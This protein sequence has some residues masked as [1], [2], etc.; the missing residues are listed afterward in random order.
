MATG[1]TTLEEFQTNA[2]DDLAE[3]YTF[4]CEGMGVTTL[5]G[6]KLKAKKPGITLNFLR[7]GLFKKDTEQP[8]R[9]IQGNP[10]NEQEGKV[11]N[12]KKSKT[13]ETE[14]SD[15]DMVITL[16]E[17]VVYP[18]NNEPTIENYSYAHTGLREGYIY[19][20]DDSD[21]DN[22]GLEYWVDEFGYLLPVIWKKGCEKAGNDGYFDI[23][24]PEGEGKDVI[25]EQDAV[26]WIAFSPVQWSIVFHKEMR[27]NAEK[28]EKRMTKVICSGFKKG[29]AS[30][31]EDVLPYNEV[32]ACFNPDQKSE[33]RKFKQKLRQ[34]KADD[35][36][37]EELKEDMFVVLHDPISCADDLAINL[38]LE[39]LRLRA[40]IESM[41]TG[42]D[43][44][45]IFDRMLK[46]KLS[47]E[48]LSK[49]Q[50]QISY[51]FTLAQTTYHLVYNDPKMIKDYDGGNTGFLNW[52][53]AGNGISKEKI[54]KILGVEER[55]EQRKIIAKHR[56]AFGSFL[57]STYYRTHWK[58][59]QEN[60]HCRILDGKERVLQH[61]SLLARH[62]HS[63]DKYLDLK[64]DDETSN[65][66]YVSFLEKI[67]KGEEGS[68]ICELLKED[69]DLE[70]ASIEAE[71]FLDRNKQIDLASKAGGVI[72]GI[73]ESFGAL[74]FKTYTTFAAQ[75]NYA[76]KITRINAVVEAIFSNIKCIKV[77]GDVIFEVSLGEFETFL[78][79]SG[80]DAV[81]YKDSI[82]LTEADKK[83]RNPKK[84]KRYQ[85]PEINTKKG[86]VRMRQSMSIALKDKYKGLIAIPLKKLEVTQEPN[87]FTLV[88]EDVTETNPKAL[89]AQAIFDS[90]VFA[91]SI[92]V[93]QVFNLAAAMDELGKENSW[94]NG[95]DALGAGV[96]VV[97]AGFYLQRAGF[98][99]G[100]VS[101]KGKVVLKAFNRARFTGLAGAGIGVAVC[102][103]DA[104]DS[105]K[106]KDYDAMASW[107]AA[108]SLY[109]VLAFGG[110]TA[111]TPLVVVGVLAIGFTVL[112]RYLTDPPLLTYFKYFPLSD[113]VEFKASPSIMPWKYN[114]GVYDNRKK[115]VKKPAWW[116]VWEDAKYDEWADFSVAFRDLTD[117]IVC[118]DIILQPTKLT[119]KKNIYVS[120]ERISA[121]ITKADIASYS[122]VV[123]FRQFLTHKE[124]FIYRIFYFENG[125]GNSSPEEL[126]IDAPVCLDR[127]ENGTPVAKVEFTLDNKY[128]SKK[129]K[130]GNFI[131]NEKGQILFVCCLHIEDNKYYPCS[132]EAEER[133]LG[134]KFT[135]H[136]NS[137]DIKTGL[138]MPIQRVNNT[139]HRSN[140]RI[141]SLENLVSNK[142]WK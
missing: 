6:P 73:L 37:D 93:L 98:L 99:A 19:I 15:E 12:K 134:A 88:P 36:K 127:T 107:V 2:Y 34:L 60:I 75:I 30:T 50:E 40:I 67:C 140:V 123:S 20:L 112:A 13:T 106:G 49:K 137:R 136:S 14:A 33:A 70:T 66:E 45:H 100:G 138:L 139:I 97:S 117:I 53:T 130:K 87:G 54:I 121:T 85:E 92:A 81:D 131:F 27:S 86:T 90:K 102:F 10:I 142:A 5:E 79:N 135:T 116:Q 89:K 55:K 129:D 141:D 120:A 122:A 69:V 76:T 47:K 78:K 59:Y 24:E 118:S 62:P 58:E 133:W 8:Y 7:L 126:L 96:E 35:K 128:L 110:I 29:Q 17:I 25:I 1:S 125:V 124:Q 11:E 28:R 4:I 114:K 91:R 46:G 61:L 9:I 31:Y 32:N 26:V 74:A 111:L 105:Y 80:Y 115:L 104:L 43:D 18:K 56:R 64:K 44:T 22:K 52:E 108:G 83:R 68:P 132:I 77:K 72:H 84:K 42:V 103:W 65:D 51:L 39:F 119:N 63:T 71:E 16:P 57:T 21:P 109:G 101:P 41:Q 48:R 38:E 95:F 82:N 23:R 3:T 113:G 94:K